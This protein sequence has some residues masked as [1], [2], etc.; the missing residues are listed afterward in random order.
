MLVC[1]SLNL[2]YI[3]IFCQTLK[4]T[5]IKTSQGKK[6]PRM[7]IGL[8]KFLWNSD[9]RVTSRTKKQE[10]AMNYSY[11]LAQQLHREAS[12]LIRNL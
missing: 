7:F 3:T 12:M 6:E 10:K 8:I 1:F 2:V 9:T 4:L 5:R 11:D